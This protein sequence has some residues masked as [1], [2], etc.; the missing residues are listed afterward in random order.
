MEITLT[1]ILLTKFVQTNAY[2]LRNNLTAHN[3]S[4]RTIF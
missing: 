2:F 1:N 4:L 3:E